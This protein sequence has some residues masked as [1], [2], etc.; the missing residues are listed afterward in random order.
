MRA[1]LAAVGIALIALFLAGLVAGRPPAATAAPVVHASGDLAWRSGSVLVRLTEDP[2]HSEE[3]VE[4]LRTDDS[5]VTQEPWLA[6]ATQDGRRLWTMCWGRGIG[7]DVITMDTLG[8]RG[9]IPSEWLK[10]EP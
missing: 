2:C 7:G 3:I 10:R 5:V 9:T 1:L 6:V 4:A 8:T